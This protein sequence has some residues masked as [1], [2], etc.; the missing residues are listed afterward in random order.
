M[1]KD[2]DIIF[3]KIGKHGRFQKICFIFIIGYSYLSFYN[4][5]SL[6]FQK[7]R[8]E[9]LCRLKDDLFQNFIPCTPETYCDKEYEKMILREESILNWA[10][11]FEL[12]CEG[13][14]M[15]EYIISAIFFGA[16]M[17]YLFLSVLADK[18]GRKKILQFEVYGMLS[19]VI[20]ALLSN[21]FYLVCI[22]WFFYEFFNHVNSLLL[23]YGS[24]TMSQDYYSYVCSLSNITFPT[25]GLITGI[26]FYWLRNWRTIHFIFTLL[27]I[28]CAI[29]FRFVIV[30]SPPYSL[31]KG[32]AKTFVETIEKIGRINNTLHKVKH[33]LEEF[34]EK[35]ITNIEHGFKV[36]KIKG[37][38]DTEQLVPS[39]ENHPKEFSLFQYLK[40]NPIAKQEFIALSYTYS[41]TLL[42]FYGVLLNIEQFDDNV[43]LFSTV[44]YI[45][46]MIAEFVSGILAQKYGRNIISKLGFYVSAIS[47]GLFHFLRGIFFFKVF[48]CFCGNFGISSCFNVMIMY[49]PEVYE[50]KVRATAASYTKIPAM[51]ITTFSP[52][53]VTRIPAPFLMFAVLC[54]SAGYLLKDVRET[55][56]PELAKKGH[57]HAGH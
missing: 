29:I 43:F 14:E 10:L 33:E 3:E 16:F 5:T 22:L 1:E 51:F 26:L 23:I 7:M 41:V 15:F 4:I 48:F 28:I 39:E 6:P 46:E 42:T 57:H 34:K 31:Q 20:L 24:E 12:D 18:Y 37:G 56:T 53:I 27:A 55:L 9:A 45:S 40:E 47:F 30:E 21:S 8:P 44:L 2:G 52:F 32:D 49:I 17:S 36:R 25:T 13:E 11:D 54:G 38:D 35:Y 19:V 50:V